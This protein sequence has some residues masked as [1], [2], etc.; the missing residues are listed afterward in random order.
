MER[1]LVATGIIE[2][3]AA[4]D[5]LP[6]WSYPAVAS[7]VESVAIDRS[8]LKDI[9]SDGAKTII[10]HFGDQWL[11][12]RTVVSKA[13]E[14]TAVTH[15]SIWVLAKDFHPELYTGLVEVLEATYQTKGSPIDVL[16][17]YRPGPPGAFNQP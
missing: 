15:F 1:N 6:V 12:Q 7:E 8:M 10:S 5:C 13:K 4:N 16:Q 9:A 17:A 14:L 3:D 2:R 11:Y